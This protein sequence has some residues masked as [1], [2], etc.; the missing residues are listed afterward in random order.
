MPLM[1]DRILSLLRVVALCAGAIAFGG[2]VIL[3]P[4]VMM[5]GILIA[6]LCGCLL[7]VQASLHRASL[8][9]AGERFCR[10]Y[11]YEHKLTQATDAEPPARCPECG[12]P[13]E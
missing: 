9:R 3:H 10:N 5:V 8:R 1:S 12:V 2:L 7:V 13:L 4:G 11:G 6:V